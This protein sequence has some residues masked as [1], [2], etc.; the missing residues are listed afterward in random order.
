MRDSIKTHDPFLDHIPD[1][2]EVGEIVRVYNTKHPEYY[3]VG[4]ATDFCE[5]TQNYTV[6]FYGR[7]GEPTQMKAYYDRVETHGNFSVPNHV[8]SNYYEDYS[9]TETHPNE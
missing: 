1:P 6:A 7:N 2:P 5:D 8:N 3:I 4:V 9:I